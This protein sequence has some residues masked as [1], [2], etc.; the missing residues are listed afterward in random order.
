MRQGGNWQVG[1]L[2]R[3]ES[4]QTLSCLQ[5]GRG[6]PSLSKLM[7]Q[8]LRIAQRIAI[9][10]GWMYQVSGEHDDCGVNG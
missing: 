6:I 7:G 3:G 1:E 4:K 5:P 9:M 8:Y 10:V 2:L